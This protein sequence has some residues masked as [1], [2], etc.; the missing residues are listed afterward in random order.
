MQ[1]TM[2]WKTHHMNWDFVVKLAVEV[3]AS[4]Q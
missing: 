3:W 2:L 1:Y 4:L